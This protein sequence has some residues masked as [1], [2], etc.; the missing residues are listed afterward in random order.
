M[1]RKKTPG[2][3][4]VLFNPAM[5]EM[6]KI[7]RTASASEARAHKISRATGVPL[8]FVVAHE[9]WVPDAAGL[10]TALHRRFRKIRVSRKR[11][12][13][14]LPLKDAVRALV[15]LS[16]AARRKDRSLLPTWKG[17]TGASLPFR[18]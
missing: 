5:P 9:E 18:V 2:Y 14:R 12:F 16:A 1:P 3:V 6:V 13:F 15:D 8:A 4:Y 11:E 17:G 7:G 10:E